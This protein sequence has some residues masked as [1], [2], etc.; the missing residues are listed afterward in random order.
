M[1]VCIQCLVLV[2]VVLGLYKRLQDSG[3]VLKLVDGNYFLNV[4]IIGVGIFFSIY[5]IE[6][7]IVQFGEDVSVCCLVSIEFFINVGRK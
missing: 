4:V 6:V 5:C 2:K 3:L 7:V 1:Q